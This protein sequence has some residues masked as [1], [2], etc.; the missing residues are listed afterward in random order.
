[1]DVLHHSLVQVQQQQ[2]LRLLSDDSIVN[3][4][5][6]SIGSDKSE[7]ELKVIVSLMKERATFISD[8]L[9]EGNYMID[10]PETWDE[11]LIQKKWKP[12]T[13]ELM[14]EWTEIIRSINPFSSDEIEL[15]FKSFLESKS[16]GLGAALL[17]FR[18]MIT[19]VGA[20]PSMFEICSFLGKEE[21]LQ[22]MER[23]MNHISNSLEA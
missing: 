18:I 7:K 15:R 11:K 17:P 14:K 21:V 6:E 19:G 4:L 10:T 2:H 20:G 5:K 23:A 8:I 16:V 3:E 1:M 22:R 13:N 9:S 12:T